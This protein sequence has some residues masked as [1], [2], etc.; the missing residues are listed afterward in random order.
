KL[1]QMSKNR[2]RQTAPN[3]SLKSSY[4]SVVVPYGTYNGQGVYMS[5][6]VPP[7]GANPQG[8]TA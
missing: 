6:G 2:Q 8:A 4:E 1:W 7:P 5:A 3:Q